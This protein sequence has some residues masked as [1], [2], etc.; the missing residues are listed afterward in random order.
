MA[1]QAQHMF[2]I[3]DQLESGSFVVLTL[4]QHNISVNDDVVKK[5]ELDDTTMVHTPF[6]SQMPTV[7]KIDTADGNFRGYL[8]L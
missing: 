5:D 2:Y 6:V 1:S 7:D 4:L 3:K 8:C